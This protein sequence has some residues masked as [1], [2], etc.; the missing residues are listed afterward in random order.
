MQPL[1][2]REVDV[3]T[4]LNLRISALYTTKVV[5]PDP[6]PRSSFSAITWS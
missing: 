4:R 1:I 6:V 2:L 3:T 5:Y